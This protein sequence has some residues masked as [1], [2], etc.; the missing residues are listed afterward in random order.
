MLDKNNIPKH[1]AI[2]MDGNGRWAKMRRLMRSA[3]HRKGMKRIKEI[4]RAANQLGIET[5]TLFAF[6]CENW[7]RPKKEVDMLMRAFSHF[8]DNDIKEL[9]KDNLRFRVIGRS[10]SLSERLLF[11]I[12]KAQE[13]TAKNTGMTLVLALNYGARQEIVDACRQIIELATKSPDWIKTLNERVFSQFLYTRNL[14]ELDLLIR[15]GAELR[16]S[17]FLL[18][19][20]SY[21]ELYFT[22]IYWPD[23]KKEDLSE[24]IKDYQERHRRFGEISPE[25]S[26][27]RRRRI[28][29]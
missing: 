5:L 12:K 24:A 7:Q 15:T 18:W 25:R 8:L 3:G 1:V 20:A 6:S 19:Q 2:I 16:L 27:G 11:K 4:T 29:E 13:L 21:A 28:K 17:N 14:P 22:K 23:F 10:V 9:N 26:E